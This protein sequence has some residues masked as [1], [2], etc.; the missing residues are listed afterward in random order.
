MFKTTSDGKCR[1]SDRSDKGNE[2]ML[3][4]LL[5]KTDKTI[6][7]KMSQQR[8][9]ETSTSDI[10][11]VARKTILMAGFGVTYLIIMVQQTPGRTKDSSMM[12]RNDA[13]DI[14]VAAAF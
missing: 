11:Q 5:S 9:P 3:V 14:Q 6:F 7:I 4:E 12:S 13:R 2:S 8:K 10:P 1:L